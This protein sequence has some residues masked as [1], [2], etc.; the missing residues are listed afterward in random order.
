[1]LEKDIE[2]SMRMGLNGARLHQKVFEERFLYH[3][4]KKGYIVWGEYPIWG[5]GS[6]YQRFDE[7]VFY[8]ITEE[9][10]EVVERDFNHPS[11]VG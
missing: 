3:C 8:S 5:L 6:S 7:K 10:T 2:L 1:M 4:D 11:I 9:W